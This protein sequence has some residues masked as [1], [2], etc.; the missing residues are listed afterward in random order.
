MEFSHCGGPL[1][2]MKASLGVRKELESNFHQCGGPV[3]LGQGSLKP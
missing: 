2:V 3:K 1:K